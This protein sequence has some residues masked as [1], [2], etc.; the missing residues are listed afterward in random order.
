MKINILSTEGLLQRWEKSLVKDQR[1]RP[2]SD[3][4]IIAF[5][6]YKDQF[7]YLTDKT[8]LSNAWAGRY[9]GAITPPSQ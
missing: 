9:V 3:Q 2:I 1:Y 5:D 8:L 7:V 4:H 6:T